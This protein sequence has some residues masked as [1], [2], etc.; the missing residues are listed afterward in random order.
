MG[1]KHGGLHL[2]RWPVRRQ[3]LRLACDFLGS[4]GCMYVACY[5][6]VLVLG[7]FL[8]CVLDLDV[9]WGLGLVLGLCIRAR[10][11]SGATM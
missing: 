10:Y 9:G 3:I 7:L 11:G 4:N 1:P 2:P 8:V 5:L 6:V